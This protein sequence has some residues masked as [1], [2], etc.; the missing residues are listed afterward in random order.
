MGESRAK[1]KGVAPPL[2]G[3]LEQT[4]SL[5]ESRENKEESLEESY[6]LPP[7]RT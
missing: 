1:N 3:L 6:G 7:A 4:A 2:E 5:G